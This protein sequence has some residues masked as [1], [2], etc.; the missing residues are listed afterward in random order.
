MKDILH[1]D[2]NNFFASVEELK[3][4]DLKNYPIA[5]C[6]DPDLRA[7]IVLAKNMKAKS[8]GVVTAETIYSAKKKCKDLVIVKSSHDDYIYYSKKVKEIYLKYTDLVESFG[9]DE[10]WLDVTNSKIFGTPIQIAEKIRK[11]VKD[12]IGLTISIGV[13]FNK[14]FA[15][16]GS[17]YKKPDAITVLNNDNYKRIVYPLDVKS[18]I[19]VGNCTKLILNKLNIFTIGDLA[20]CN[21]DILIKH[22][23]KNGIELYNMANGISSD[24][25]SNFYD[26]KVPKSISKGTTFIKD[27]NNYNEISRCIK[28]LLD[29]VVIELRDNN[30]KC[31]CVCLHIKDNMFISQSKQ[32]KITLTSVYSSILQEA[33]NLLDEVYKENRLIRAVTV[34]VTNFTEDNNQISF[35]D[36][37]KEKAADTVDNLRKK[38]GK[39][40]IMYGSIIK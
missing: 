24:I 39:N 26:K 38:Y 34:A 17:D 35:L 32:K 31:E 9:I 30:L 2:L 21:K 19:F 3:N 4:P 27:T 20:H 33:L 25:V 28:H 13:S 23:N 11:E 29:D 5:V 7:G 18:L 37:N 15:K 10:A 16:L 22:L 8:Y 12:S 36:D 14:V 1:C 40:K 6:G